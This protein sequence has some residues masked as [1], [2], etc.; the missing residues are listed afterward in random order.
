MTCLCSHRG[1]AKVER[2]PFGT[3]ALERA[4]VV[5][6][7][8]GRFTRGKVPVP[9]VQGLGRASGPVWAKRRIPPPSGFEP[10]TVKWKLRDK[11]I[12]R[13]VKHKL[14]RAPCTW[15]ARVY[16]YTRLHALF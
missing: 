14:T 9:T 7:S 11:D 13:V 2:H 8:P 15:N 12:M 4:G 6:K 10:R 5:S 3:S 16:C 1:E